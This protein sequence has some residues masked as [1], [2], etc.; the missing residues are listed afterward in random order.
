MIRKRHPILLRA[1][2]YSTIAYFYLRRNL[3][4]HPLLRRKYTYAAAAKEAFNAFLAS[5]PADRVFVHVA[6]SV[7]KRFASDQK[8]YEYLIDALDH[9]FS[10]V[11]SQAFTPAGRKTKCFDPHRDAPAYGGF[12]ARFFKDMS[13][14]NLDPCYSVMARGD[15]GWDPQALSFSPEGIFKQMIHEDMYCLNIGLDY[16]TCSMLHL[17][18][19]EQRPPY[20]FFVEEDFLLQTMGKEYPILYNLHKNQ[21]AYSVKGFVW[22]NKIRLARD[23]KEA[24]LV[25][26]FRAGGVP[27][28]YFSMRDV[29]EF[30][31]DR[32][33]QDP[34]YLVTW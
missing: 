30:V 29:Y 18:E 17:I 25:H 21:G 32:L 31:S 26:A 19:Y 8:A 33:R 34:F 7:A 20:L 10:L 12:A 4:G 5:V 6:L 14:R 15:T 11:V 3:W 9:H 28:C 1:S 16:P 13:W 2:V 22:W 24:G 23:L 27:L